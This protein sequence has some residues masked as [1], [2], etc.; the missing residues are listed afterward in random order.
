MKKA[1]F[2]IAVLLLAAMAVSAAPSESG[3]MP[4]T[5][6]VDGFLS[7]SVPAFPTTNI[8]AAEAT[9]LE[10]AGKLKIISNL[11]NWYIRV[12]SVNRGLVMY[13]AGMGPAY[14]LPYTIAISGLIDE[15]KLD[16]DVESASQS[17]TALAGN[18]YTIKLR[19][20]PSATFITAG[21][22]SDTIVI[23]LSVR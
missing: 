11:N 4:I 5:V 22:Y 9:V 13:S 16:S 12:H 3:S 21:N 2:F 7:I 6:T 19:F 10:P 1:I 8:N 14:S 18:E 17:A 23:T 15:T 20:G